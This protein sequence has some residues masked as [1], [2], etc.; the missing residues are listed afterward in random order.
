MTSKLK[1][2]SKENTQTISGGMMGTL[3]SSIEQFR[4]QK[5][6]ETM[7]ELYMNC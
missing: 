4:S 1:K 7:V 6:E 5:K 3:K 2:R